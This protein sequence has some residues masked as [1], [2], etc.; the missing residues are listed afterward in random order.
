MISEFAE[1]VKRLYDARKIGINKVRDLL[2]FGR[3]TD[4]EYNYIIG[5]G[6]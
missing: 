1:S 5:K 6:A 2:S 4:V 3:I